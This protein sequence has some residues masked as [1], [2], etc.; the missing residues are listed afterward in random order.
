M[1]IT[2]NS[3]L[4]QYDWPSIFNRPVMNGS[5]LSWTGPSG[6]GPNNNN[7]VRQSRTLTVSGAV[8][9]TADNQTIE[10]L[11]ILGTVRIRH[12][13]I[14]LRQCAITVDDFACVA[15][16]AGTPA[17]LVIEDCL[18]AGITGSATGIQPDNAA[19]NIIRR[20]NIYR[21][22][23]KGI[24]IGADNQIIQDN[25]IH[26]LGRDQPQAG[27]TGDHID[28]IQGSGGFTA[29]HID[30]N[31]IF[32]IDTSCI[33]MQNEGAGFSGLVVTNNLLVMLN[34]AA[35]LFVDGNFSGGPV[36]NFSVIGN[37]MG[38]PGGVVYN[39]ISNITGTITYTGN[40]DWITGKP[41]NVGD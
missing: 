3:R 12:N 26:D 41:V 39:S 37:V 17:N 22:Y 19:G 31:A 5:V 6:G 29:L 18:I 1:P 25:W 30:H 33:I 32:S 13:N 35:C 23:D 20:C 11:F 10:G 9:S 16:D 4:A 24:A 15:C 34:G 38:I 7:P 8:V 40:A 28:G 21:T 27:P 14:T 36:G 2:S